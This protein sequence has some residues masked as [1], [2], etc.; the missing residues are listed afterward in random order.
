MFQGLVT[1]PDEVNLFPPEGNIEVKSNVLS[2]YQYHNI[3]RHFISLVFV[4]KQHS[5]DGLI[6]TKVL[7][8]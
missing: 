7:V 4:L 1:A 2:Q 3:K 5:L 8:M 6:V